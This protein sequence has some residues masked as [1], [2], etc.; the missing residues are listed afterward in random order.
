MVSA[1]SFQIFAI[2]TPYNSLNGGLVSKIG[3]NLALSS[4]N[5]FGSFTDIRIQDDDMTVGESEC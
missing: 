3:W 4:A 5:L 2:I 1:Y